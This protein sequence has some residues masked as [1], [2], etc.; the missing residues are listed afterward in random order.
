MGKVFIS[1]SQDSADHSEKVKNFAD[2]LRRLGVDAELD[3]Y[4]PTP[5]LG[6]PTYM[7]QNILESEFVICVC[8]AKY[9][10]RFEQRDPIGTGKGAKFEGKLITDI[11]YE[12]E[13]NDKFI[14]VFI[15]DN[16]DTSLIPLVLLS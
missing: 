1:Y 8:S 13:I 12:A 4:T 6:W 16:N 14:P 3:K 5:S 7:V 15:D 2:N 11:I 10:N 9:K